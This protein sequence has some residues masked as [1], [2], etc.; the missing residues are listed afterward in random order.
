MVSWIK[1]FST[2]YHRRVGRYPV[3]HTATSWWKTC[4]GN[5]PGFG[6]TN[7]LS[8]SD[9]PTILPAG[10]SHYT[11]WRYAGSGPAPGGQDSFNGDASGL[12]Q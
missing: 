3:I 12:K 1:D 10:W 9:S 8:L 11:F 4:T 6:S 5:Y 7:P 2:T